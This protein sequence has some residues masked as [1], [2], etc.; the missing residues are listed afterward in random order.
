MLTEHEEQRNFVRWFRLQYPGVRIF[1]IPNGGQRSRT[2]GAKL[3]AEGVMA[4]VP[5]LYV[6][7][8]NLWIE[9]KREERGVL[10]PFQ[11][12]WFKYLRSINH[13]VIL[14]EGFG[15]ARKKVIE[16]YSTMN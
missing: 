13:S 2:T 16:L 9:M 5:D 3:K 15:D 14:G 12:D 7:S 1:A 6:P 4:G 8:W 10:S 11:K